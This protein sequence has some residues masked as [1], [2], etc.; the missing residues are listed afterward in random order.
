MTTK[1]ED[2]IQNK[3][4]AYEWSVAAIQNTLAFAAPYVLAVTATAAVIIYHSYNLA[5]SES[6]NLVDA[7]QT[8][9][10]MFNEAVSHVLPG[11]V[12]A[13]APLPAI[14]IG[15]PIISAISGALYDFVIDTF[16]SSEDTKISDITGE[17]VELTADI[18]A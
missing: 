14:L 5:K 11:Y 8:N 16:T 9:G 6:L 2:E 17:S 18:F 15:W 13:I 10:D 3:N 1:K 7:T 12:M 4:H